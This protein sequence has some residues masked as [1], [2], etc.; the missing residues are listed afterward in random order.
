ML[1]HDCIFFKSL[2][3]YY[4]SSPWSQFPWLGKNTGDTYGGTSQ[5][6]LPISTRTQ[7]PDT[8]MVSA[9]PTSGSSSIGANATLSPYGLSSQ[10]LSHNHSSSPYSTALSVSS[11][12]LHDTTVTAAN[13]T[14]STSSSKTP[15]SVL[16]VPWSRFPWIGNHR[17][18]YNSSSQ[19][20]LSGTSKALGGFD[21]GSMQAAVPAS[22]SNIETSSPYT[23]PHQEGL[24][25]PYPSLSTNNTS[26]SSAFNTSES[27]SFLASSNTISATT[28]TKSCPNAHEFL[29]PLPSTI[30]PLG[31]AGHGSS[32][33]ATSPSQFSK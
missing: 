27:M 6:S 10:G 24:S 28:L 4:C 1:F 20:G 9:F 26:N 33:H 30:P 32:Q 31:V 5:Y 16:G 21:S 2:I 17:E 22:S 8:S 12:V 25:T 29:P 15:S 13:A 11:P 23:F 18:N 14:S 7:P 19:Y 3:C